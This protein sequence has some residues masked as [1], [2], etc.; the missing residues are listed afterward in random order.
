M[1]HLLGVGSIAEPLTD[2]GQG[3]LPTWESPKCHSGSAGPSP[4]AALC[5]CRVSPPSVLSPQ[6]RKWL[7]VSLPSRWYPLGPGGP[8]SARDRQHR[9]AVLR[10]VRVGATRLRQRKDRAHHDPEAAPIDQPRDVLELRPARLHDEECRADAWVGTLFRGGGDGDQTATWPPEH[11]PGAVERLAAHRVE[12]HVHLRY[13]VLETPRGEA[14]R[15]GSWEPSRRE[16][17]AIILAQNARPRAG[18]ETH[19]E[20]EARSGGARRRGARGTA[21]LDRGGLGLG[22]SRHRGI[23]H[24]AQA[25]RQ[26][27]LSLPRWRRLRH[28]A[29]QPLLAA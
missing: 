5:T 20:G 3:T 13:D 26:P 2:S 29:G 14:G 22:R 7:K 19:G 6:G 11:L 28:R 23:S 12:N 16:L 4:W 1:R 10:L 18:E 25:G 9:L 24:R 21:R 8:G 17:C 27:G 15:R